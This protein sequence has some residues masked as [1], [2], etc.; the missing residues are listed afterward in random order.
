[1][2][3]WRNWYSPHQRLPPLNRWVQVLAYDYFSGIT[4]GRGQLW[5]RKL[6]YAFNVDLDKGIGP[7]DIVAWRYLERTKK[8]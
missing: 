5:G 4:S 1:M 8:R 6:K 3:R 7:A 2:S